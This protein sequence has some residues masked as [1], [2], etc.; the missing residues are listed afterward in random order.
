MKYVLC[1]L[2]IIAC[3]P[4]TKEEHSF[5]IGYNAL[6]E[7]VSCKTPKGVVCPAIGNLEN[8]AFEEQCL[9]AGLEVMNCG[10]CAP[11]LCSGKMAKGLDMNGNERSCVVAADDI[12]CTMEYTPADQFADEC[13][14]DGGQ[15]V[16]CGCHDYICIPASLD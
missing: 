7:Q 1:V 12:I 14:K 6:G 2:L 3:Q 13:V 10:N 11:S 15:A 16:A 5:E 9:A 4:V 8:E